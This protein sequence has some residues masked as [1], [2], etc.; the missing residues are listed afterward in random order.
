MALSAIAAYG[1]RQL[2]LTDTAGGTA[3]S[4]PKAM[5]LHFTERVAATEFVAEGEL[6]GLCAYTTGIDWEIEAGG[7]SLA[8]WAKLTGRS[9][10][11]AGATPNQT[12]TLSANVGDAFPYVRIY[13][14]A[15]GDGDDDVHCRIFRAKLVSL[16]GTFRNGEFWVSSCAGVGVKDLVNGAF[17]F[18][19]HET[20]ATL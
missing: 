2:K 11:A 18:V 17:E 12:L 1:L 14:K 6:V 15:L 16:E 10:A 19:Q 5:V 3:V 4:L 9:A 7:I 8:A 13:G 20:A